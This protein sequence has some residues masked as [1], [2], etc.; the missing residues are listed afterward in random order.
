MTVS[1]HLQTQSNPFQPIDLAVPSLHELE[2][3]VA[4]AIK[5]KDDF[6]HSR[7]PSSLSHYGYWVL[8]G[9]SGTASAVLTGASAALGVKLAEDIYE[10][11]IHGDNPGAYIPLGAMVGTVVVGLS[12]APALGLAR[13]CGHA[14][15]KITDDNAVIERA[16]QHDIDDACQR[17]AEVARAL[18]PVEFE[19]LLK[20]GVVPWPSLIEACGEDV[21]KASVLADH[22]LSAQQLAP[23]RRLADLGMRHCSAVGDR[24]LNALKA[25]AAF[26]DMLET[27]PDDAADVLA[28]LSMAI[29]AMTEN[30]SPELETYLQDHPA[31]A[32]E[33]LRHLKV[34]VEDL[35]LHDL[36]SQI[37]Q[38]RVGGVAMAITRH[39]STD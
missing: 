5:A 2:A 19:Q 39:G 11:T 33:A 12:L 6:T 15:R 3:Q 21:D 16:L 14:V 30:A 29:N 8:A 24:L 4:S 20:R 26:I 36:L 9:A 18:S 31:V 1:L 35:G 22:L 13:L 37:E 32:R 10:S 17:L 7:L 27:H 23:L 34:R 38:G 28:M 25:P